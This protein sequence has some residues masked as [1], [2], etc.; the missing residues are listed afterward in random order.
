MFTQK[1]RFSLYKSLIDQMPF[2]VSLDIHDQSTWIHA[3]NMST[4]ELLLDTRVN[5]HFSKVLRHLKRLG[6]KN[7]ILVI[8]EA[9]PHGFAPYRF[10]HKHGFSAKV[11]A[12]V[13]IPNRNRPDKTDRNDAIDNLRLYHGGYLSFVAVPDEAMEQARDCLRY[14]VQTV[15]GI[16]REKQRLL[17]LI[18][19]LG[20]TYTLT[21]SNWTK[22]HYKWLSTVEVSACTRT[23]MNAHLENILQMEIQCQSI[24]KSLDEFFESHPLYASW[25][26]GYMAIRGIGKVYAMTM[27]L[28]GGDLTRFRHPN[29][30]MKWAGLIPGKRQS[31]SSDPSLRITKA[32]NKFLRCAIVG[33]A[34]AYQDA[35]HLYSCRQIKQMPELEQKFFEKMQARLTHTY[36]KLRAR[37]K[38]GNKARVAVAREMC[39]FL[40]EYNRDFMK[41]AGDQITSKAA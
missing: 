26:A 14:R 3:V 5:G 35:R 32:G 15:W 39:G 6:P 37:G 33:A 16:A 18:K 19:R 25:L 28:E 4:G 34:R 12:P 17:S 7:K 10:L 29:Q 30:I 27:V 20:L 2:T 31:G 9:G 21:K 23:V 22:A 13:S 24:E 38:H 11:I 1:S 36:R 41:K 8:Y 40:W